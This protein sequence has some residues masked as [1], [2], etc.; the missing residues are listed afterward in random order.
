MPLWCEFLDPFLIWFYRLTGQA[1]LDFFIGSFLLAVICL[2]LGEGTLYLVFRVSRK[3]LA[4][5]MAEADKYQTLSIE[6]LK[7]GNREAY[8]AAN[9]LAKEA[10]GRS[11]MHQLTLSG[12]FL[13]PVC[14]TL[15]WMQ[16][17]FLEVEF[18]IPGTDWSLGFIGV[19][20][21][22]YVTAY[23]L[24]K[25]LRRCWLI[26]CARNQGAPELVVRPAKVALSAGPSDAPDPKK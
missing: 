10:F 6:A 11:F 25:G 7:A 9:K 16:Y 13:W 15:A 3:R 8:E 14:F 22:I 12:A 18:P 26:F 24:L 5:K 19:F 17:R 21:L 1:W 20:V 4:E 2:L 23:F